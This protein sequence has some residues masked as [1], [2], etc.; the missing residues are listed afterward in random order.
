MTKYDLHP[1]L[2]R[3]SKMHSPTGTGIL[4]VAN[5]LLSLP[6]WKHVKGVSSKARSIPGYRGEKIRLRLF[7]PKGVSGEMPCLVYFHGGGFAIK[8][9]PY[10]YELAQLYAREARCRVAF[11]DYRLALR[12]PFPTPAEDCFAA[13]RYVLDNAARLGIR[14]DRIAVGGDSAGGALAAACCLMAR[15][16]GVPIPCFQ[17]LVYP[18]TDRRMETRSMAAFPDTPMWNGEKNKAMWQ[19]YL[20]EDADAP[21]EYAS[22]MEAPSLISMPNAYVE[23]AEFD[24]LRDEGAAYAVALRKAGAAV[25]VNMTKGTVHGYDILMKKEIVQT[26]IDRRC[27]ALSRAL[28]EPGNE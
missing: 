17:L 25:E 5:A 6:V 21:L 1:Q 11:V 15:D 9:A 26:A 23:T 10:H 16:R 3:L 24:C 13:Y 27:I 28:H 8:A 14:R 22:P 4:P 18:V 2:S 20:P 19:L 12:H 7:S